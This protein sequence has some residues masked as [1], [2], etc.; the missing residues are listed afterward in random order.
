MRYLKGMVGV[1]SSED[2]QGADNRFAIAS[3]FAVKLTAASSSDDATACGGDVTF[4]CD[5]TL[6][7]CC[8]LS[9]EGLFR[10]SSV[11]FGGSDL[12]ANVSGV[13][14]F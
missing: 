12:L 9:C 1:S 2:L 6:S 5:V 10:C 3:F 8:N 4:C 11:M 13:V 14:V 7:W